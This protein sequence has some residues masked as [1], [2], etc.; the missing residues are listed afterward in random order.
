VVASAQDIAA[1][2]AYYVACSADK[3]VVQPTSVIGSIGVIFNTFDL[4]GSLDKIGARTNVIKSGPLKDMASP[5]KPMGDDERAV[6]QERT[7][8]LR[9][10]Q[11][12]KLK[13][14]EKDALANN[15]KFKN[16][17][18]TEK[19]MTT[20]NKGKALYMHCLPADITDVS[21]KEG[22]VAASV[23]EKSR[24]AT[25]REAS[26]K[27]FV[28]AAMILLTRFE[29]GG[30]VIKQLLDRGAPRRGA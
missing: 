8:I 2:G 21:C 27:P 30:K 1:S 26:H 19:L 7:K 16:W 20:T 28:I 11:Q 4:S 13:A 15:A 22:E 6:M 12:D 24:I 5:F 10:G 25:Y 29:H 9:A 3:I 18:C 14:L 23:F 17:E